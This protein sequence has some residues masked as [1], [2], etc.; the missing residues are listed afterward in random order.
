MAQIIERIHSGT[1]AR[2]TVTVIGSG[3]LVTVADVKAALLNSP[4]LAHRATDSRV[5][6]KLVRG[7]NTTGRAEHGWSRFTIHNQL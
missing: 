6:G 3:S 7:L 4:D 2:E 1:T 5:L